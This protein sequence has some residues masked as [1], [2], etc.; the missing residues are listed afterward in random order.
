M[1]IRT[2]STG[3]GS[4]QVWIHYL[5]TGIVF[6][7]TYKPSGQC[8]TSN[9]TGSAFVIGGG[10]TWEDVYPLA[11]AKNVVVVGGGTPVSLN[12]STIPDVSDSNVVRWLCWGMDARRGP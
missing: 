5:K 8:Q 9:W 6:Q 7:E 4:L 1:L 10:Y 2:R 3:Y 11:A 12:L